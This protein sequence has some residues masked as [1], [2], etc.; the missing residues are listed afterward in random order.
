MPHQRLGTRPVD[1]IVRKQRAHELTASVRDEVPSGLG[2]Q[3]PHRLDNVVADDGRVA[4]N[5]LLRRSRNNVLLGRVHE[6]A[7]LVSRR[8]RLERRRVNL[9]RAAAK[10][11]C[12]GVLHRP[13]KLS[14]MSS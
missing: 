5:R 12:I 9:V 10:Q 13:P 6:I 8:H 2:L 4:P 3:R 1:Q 11:E 14:P 7:E